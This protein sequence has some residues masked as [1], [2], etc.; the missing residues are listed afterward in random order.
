[1]AALD[2]LNVIRVLFIPLFG[3]TLI[4]VNIAVINTG[5]MMG[6]TPFVD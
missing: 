6:K 1:M 4:I 5:H 3:I 2:K